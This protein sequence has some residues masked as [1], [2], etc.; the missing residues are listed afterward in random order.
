M[1]NYLQNDVMLAIFNIFF[2]FALVCIKWK[3][4]DLTLFLANDRTQNK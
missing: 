2:F 3:K 4:R 1:Q